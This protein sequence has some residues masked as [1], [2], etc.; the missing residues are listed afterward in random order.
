VLPLAAD[1]R[2]VIVADG[3]LE[4]LPFA[5][6]PVPGARAPEPLAATRGRS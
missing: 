3:A 1:A 5:M 4:Y 6:L 2:L